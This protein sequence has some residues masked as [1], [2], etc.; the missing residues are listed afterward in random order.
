MG[1]AANGLHYIGVTKNGVDVYVDL[2]HSAAAGHI[3]QQPHILTLA[4]TMLAALRLTGEALNTEYD[5]GRTIG[6]AD[7]VETTSND[8]IVYAKRLKCLTYT[9][10]VRKRQ[11][12]PSSYLSMSFQRLPDGSYE[13]LDVWIGN[14]FPPF[15]MA[16]NETP[17]SR[18]FWEKHAIVLDGQPL[19]LR[20]L[21]KDSPF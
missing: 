11:L 6:N 12:S 19:Q 1:H 14:Q 16:E 21:T 9:R 10:F 20:T 7:V 2:I 13:L 8:H 15:P 3:S 17:D 5:F 4:K 18:P